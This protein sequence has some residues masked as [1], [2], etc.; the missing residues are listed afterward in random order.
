MQIRQPLLKIKFQAISDQV[1]I[2]KKYQT[3]GF[4]GQRLQYNISYQD[5]ENILA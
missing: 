4:H 2:L 5:H 1:R 3:Y